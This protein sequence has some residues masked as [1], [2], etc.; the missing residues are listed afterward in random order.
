[1]WYL[2]VMVVL[3]KGIFDR[4]DWIRM[5]LSNLK[6]IIFAFIYCF[7]IVG[8]E[9]ERERDRESSQSNSS[10]FDEMQ[11]RF[12]QKS[13]ENMRRIEKYEDKSG[14]KDEILRRVEEYRGRDGGVP[15]DID[16]EKMRKALDKIDQ[17]MRR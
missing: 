1:M 3:L 16:Q 10:R 15:R 14:R 7:V 2:I 9:P 12:D 6:Y 13:D 8:C 5:V 11:K 4:K 17:K